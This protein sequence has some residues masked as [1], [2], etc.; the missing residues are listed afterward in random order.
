MS[1]TGASTGDVAPEAPS[2]EDVAATRIQALVRAKQASKR[3]A[4]LNLR[5]SATV[6][7][8]FGFVSVS[9]QK[10]ASYRST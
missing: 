6:V 1:R 2:S 8:V 7:A 5:T 3:W 10:D 4:H 9:P